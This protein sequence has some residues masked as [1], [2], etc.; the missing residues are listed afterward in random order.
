MNGQV[1]AKNSLRYNRNFVLL[2]LGRMVSR[3][4]DSLYSLGITWFILDLTGA[5]TTMSLYLATGMMTYLL[6]GPLAGV[7][8]DRWDRVRII[9]GAD[10]IRGLLIA[11][12]GMFYF[13]GAE[14]ELLLAALFLTTVL[15]NICSALFNPAAT[16]LTPRIVPTNM[17]TRANSLQSMVDSG[18]SITGLVLGGIIYTLVGIQGIFVINAISFLLS[19][20]SEMFIRIPKDSAESNEDQQLRNGVRLSEIRR[21][22]KE[23]YAYILSQRW[24]ILIT[25][26]S[27]M[28]NLFINPLMTIY[29]PYIVN[30]IMQ[31]QPVYLSY[32]QAALGAGVLLGSLAMS[33]QSPQETIAGGLRLSYSILLIP[34]AA[35]AA[36]LFLYASETIQLMYAL[37]VFIGSSFIMGFMTAYVNIPI[38]V[39]IQRKVPNAI[40]GRVDAVFSTLLMTGIPIGMI[41]G[42]ILT[43]RLPMTW[44]LA[45]TTG[46]L[47]MVG[48]GMWMIKLDF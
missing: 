42:G 44:M 6:M 37:N 4:G 32:I 28:I 29:I 16:A 2:F 41:A 7:L 19:G 10:V 5:G 21:E 22:F 8:V 34:L 39:A 18:S 40:L 36:C 46:A 30:Q 20:L 47:I 25:I 26:F 12:A 33:T 11:L 43:D 1:S 45:G 23:G 9:Y 27:F 17:L 38:N 13:L 35:M 31:I 3:V 48:L 24:L 14:P 15:T